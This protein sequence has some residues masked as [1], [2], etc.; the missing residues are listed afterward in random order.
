MVS[1]DW[2]LSGLTSD[3]RPALARALRAGEPVVLATLAAADAGAPLGKGAQM[4]FT[5]AEATGYLSGGC[6]EADVALHAADVLRDGEMRTL[7]YGDGGPP[8]IRLP[9]GGRIVVWLERVLADDAAAHRLVELERR[10]R[11]A[12]W[13]SDGRER[14]CLTPSQSVPEAYRPGTA[15][16]DRVALSEDGRRLAR[17]YDPRQRLIVVGHD[18]IALATAD[19]GLRMEWETT[20]VRPFGPE[21][22]PPLAGLGYSRG[23]PGAALRALDPDPWT[24]VVIATHS[25]DHEHTATL[26]AVCS[27]AGYVGL[28]GSRRRLPERLSRLRA[29]GAPARAVARVRAPVGLPLGATTPFEIAVSIVAEI[30]E[31]A[32]APRREPLWSFE[33]AAVP[34]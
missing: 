5:R 20:L 10:R 12:L 19:L 4:L 2:P 23:E 34:A 28:L 13:L 15:A 14:R 1:E 7:V 17:R 9:C 33:A 26:A 27:Q 16:F 25:H 31:A 30:V 21:A 3:V 8:D 32:N 11:P 18:P 6:V 22:A 29:D 24:S